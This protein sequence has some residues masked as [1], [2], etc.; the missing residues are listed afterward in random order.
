VTTLQDALSQ[1]SARQLRLAFI[2][3]LWNGRMDFKESTMVEVRKNE[4]TFNVSLDHTTLAPLTRF[5][6]LPIIP[7]CA[8]LL[9]NG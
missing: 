7:T 5:T 1:H 3:Q 4:S 2:N 8:E 9:R 6:D